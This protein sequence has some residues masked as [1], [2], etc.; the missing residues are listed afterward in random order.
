[1]SSNNE[2]RTLG[3]QM[4]KMNLHGYHHHYHKDISAAVKT[5]WTS[6]STVVRAG[7]SYHKIVHHQQMFTLKEQINI[8]AGSNLHYLHMSQ[9][10]HPHL[11]Q[12]LA[13]TLP[14]KRHTAP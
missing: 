8:E 9:N 7:H 13:S 14:L 2:A 3:G 10:K 12:T 6:G 1:M 5:Q 11:Q 4:Q